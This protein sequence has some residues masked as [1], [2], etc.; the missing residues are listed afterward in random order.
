[1]SEPLH[2]EDPSGRA[3]GAPNSPPQAP[4]PVPGRPD[5]PAGQEGLSVPPDDRPDEPPVPHEVP[6]LQHP[7]K[8][9][10]LVK[11]PATPAPALTA[12]QR[13]PL[14]DT[15]R[16]SGLPAGDFAPPVGVSRHTLY[17]WKRRF[18]A[19]GPAG[20]V[21]RPRGEPGCEARR[22][23]LPEKASC[24]GDGRGARRAWP[25]WTGRTRPRSG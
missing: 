21:D 24:A 6:R 15:W 13:L 14:L 12:Q 2:P 1:M 18:E 4:G 8:G 7:T 23:R 5:R 25:G 17:D 16:R 3:P 11:P 22:V 20:L 10:R 19:D 9:R